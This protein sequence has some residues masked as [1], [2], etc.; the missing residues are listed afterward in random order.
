MS[1]EAWR[2]TFQ[3]SEQ[4]AKAAFEESQRW[5][6]LF[7]MATG[8]VVE[9]TEAAG[10]RKEDQLMGGTFQALAAIEKLKAR[11][12]KAEQWNREM[13]NKAASNHLEGY[14]ELGLRTATAETARDELASQ[15]TSL[16]EDI[17][18]L[19]RLVGKIRAAA[20]DP[21]GKLMQPELIAHIT[22]LNAHQI[23]D[24]SKMVSDRNCTACDD[25]FQ[26]Q[27]EA[28]E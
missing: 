13:V 19:L 21:N 11:A 24:A 16:Q 26:P 12:L 10:I 28:G 8:S 7:A 23:A 9:L 15:V 6:R 27:P 22:A 1:Y 2:I 18:S 25:Q 17:S 14:R 5:E 4:A 20:G 3:D